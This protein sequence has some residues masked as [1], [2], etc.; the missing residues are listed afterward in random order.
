MHWN[1]RVV[2]HH[3]KNIMG[4]PDVGYAIHEV[5]Y[6]DDGSIRGMTQD[7]VSPYG[8]TPEELKDDLER[9]LEAIS[10]PILDF[11]DADLDD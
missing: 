10:K 8:D 6:D 9:M 3:T 2:R 11:D 5:Y 7:A 4:D 1:H